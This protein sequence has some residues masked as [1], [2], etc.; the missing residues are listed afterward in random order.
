VEV[1]LW[2]LR[3]VLILPSSMGIQSGY[4][5]VNWLPIVARSKNAV[6][7]ALWERGQE[8]FAAKLEVQRK[9][10]LLETLPSIPGE[11]VNTMSDS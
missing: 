8:L 3:S 2:T 11:A 5:T 7:A 10:G 4:L 6:D 1:F 9:G